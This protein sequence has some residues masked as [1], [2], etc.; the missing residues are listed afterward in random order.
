MNI[1]N[2]YGRYALHVMNLI[3]ILL[4]FVLIPGGHFNLRYTKNYT[5]M[6]GFNAQATMQIMRLYIKKSYKKDMGI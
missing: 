5:F 3:Y 4:F 2:I 1:L 6:C